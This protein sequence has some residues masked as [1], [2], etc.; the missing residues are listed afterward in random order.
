ML[1]PEGRNLIVQELLSEGANS[2]TGLGLQAS[3][4]VE[5]DR[6]RCY[7]FKGRDNALIVST[8]KM[9]QLVVWQWARWK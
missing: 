1:T 9:L 5:F 3:V 4:S 7:A 8:R 6:L 2:M